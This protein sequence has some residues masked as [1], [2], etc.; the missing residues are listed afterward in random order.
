M[1]RWTTCKKSLYIR[2]SWS[3]RGCPSMTT[4][5]TRSNTQ[6]TCYGHTQFQTTVLHLTVRAS[7]IH[8]PVFFLGRQLSWST[9][10]PTLTEPEGILRDTRS[11]HRL[12]SS[13]MWWPVFCTRLHGITSQREHYSLPCS[14]KPITA[15]HRLPDTYIQSTPSHPVRKGT[16]IILNFCVNFSSLK[17][18]LKFLEY[19]L[20]TRRKWQTTVHTALL[21]DETQFK[22]VRITL[23]LKYGGIISVQFVRTAVYRQ[24][25]HCEVTQGC[26]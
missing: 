16:D 17:R 3:G 21:P 1:A 15:S 13:G 2:N 19:K 4:C 24:M 20:K 14:Q 9:T 11:P 5:A 12:L 25:T 18:V 6:N 7:F 23:A 10:S 22:A 26:V 8:Y